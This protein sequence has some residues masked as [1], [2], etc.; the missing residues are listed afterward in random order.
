[1]AT[2]NSCFAVVEETLQM[3]TFLEYFVTKFVFAKTIILSIFM[4]SDF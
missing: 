3:L 1:M 4:N 2:V